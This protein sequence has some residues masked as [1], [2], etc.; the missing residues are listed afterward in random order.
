MKI[1][2]LCTTRHFNSIYMN[3]HSCSTTF[4]T[5]GCYHNIFKHIC[6]HKKSFILLHDIQVDCS[7]VNNIRIINESENDFIAKNVQTNLRIR[8]LLTLKSQPINENILKC[9]FINKN[10]YGNTGQI[11][12]IDVFY[13]QYF[14]RRNIIPVIS[15]IGIVNHNSCVYVHP[16]DITCYLVPHFDNVTVEYIQCDFL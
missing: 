10:L 16:T 15:P 6:K 13:I 4:S 14:I 8:Q 2:Q 5:F 9:N 11:I 1:I 7:Y 12:N 3:N